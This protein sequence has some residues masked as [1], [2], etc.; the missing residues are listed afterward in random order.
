M[1]GPFLVVL[2]PHQIAFEALITSFFGNITNFFTRPQG[3]NRLLVFS[4]IPSWST[5]SGVRRL[6]P[7][8][9]V[10]KPQGSLLRS[11]FFPGCTHFFGDLIWTA[12]FKIWSLQKWLPILYLEP[13]TL[14]Q[15][16][17]SHLQLPPWHLSGVLYIYWTY[18]V[19]ACFN[20]IF[21]TTSVNGNFVLPVVQAANL[22]VILDNSV[23]PNIQSIG[24]LFSPPPLLSPWPIC[25]LLDQLP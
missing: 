21:P 2:L 3:C 24:D 13:L 19:Q 18:H 16:P 14:P 11:L 22:E 10:T 8:F 25:L 5:C 9:K 6:S 23:K 15:T 1:N 7:P 4:F 20:Q 17:D 12:G